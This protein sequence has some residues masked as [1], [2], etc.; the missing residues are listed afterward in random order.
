MTLGEV[1]KAWRESFNPPLTIPQAACI[2]RVSLDTW[3]HIEDNNSLPYAV[4]DLEY[5]C[6]WLG[7]SADN[8]LRLPEKQA[9]FGEYRQDIIERYKR[10]GD[11]RPDFFVGQPRGGE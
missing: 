5:L 9:T 7:L 2:A 3:R 10:T 8:L 11:P 1:M 6:L 4:H